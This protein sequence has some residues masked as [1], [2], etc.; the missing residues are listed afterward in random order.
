MND[1]CHT[2]GNFKPKKIMLCIQKVGSLYISC[3]YRNH[4]ITYFYSNQ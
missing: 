4:C 3:Y 2:K 1:E